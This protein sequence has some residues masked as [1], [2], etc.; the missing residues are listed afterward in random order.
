AMIVNCTIIRMLDG[1]RLRTRLMKKFEDEITA[2]TAIAITTVVS[3]F[4]VTASAEQMPSTCSAMGLLLNSG[5]TRTLR[6]FADIAPLLPQR[7]E[8]GPEAL[9]AEPELHR[10]FHAAPGNRRSRQSIHPVRFLVGRPGAPANHGNGHVAIL[11]EQLAAIPRGLP[12]R[13]R[14]LPPE[15]GRLPMLIER[16]AAHRLQVGPQREEAVHRR[17]EPLAFDRQHE[18]VALAR[19]V[20]PLVGDD[21]IRHAGDLC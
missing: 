2:I 1:V 12:A 11:I 7:L 21:V 10:G 3:I 17:P 9:F 5:S 15:A 13:V 20:E 4:V 14:D 19:F 16:E 18:Q 6:A 8:I